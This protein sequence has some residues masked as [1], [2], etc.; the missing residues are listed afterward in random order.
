MLFLAV[1]LHCFI[2][3]IK[4]SKD[5]K[6]YELIRF[7]NLNS[8]AEC[9]ANNILEFDALNQHFKLDLT[10]QDH[11]HSVTDLQQHPD[12]SCAHL[13]ELCH[14]K[15]TVI[16]PHH[17]VV[18]WVSIS[19]C[20]VQDIRVFITLHNDTLIIRPTQS[21]LHDTYFI[22][23]HSANLKRT[24]QSINTR[25][26]LPNTGAKQ[27]CVDDHAY[28]DTICVYADVNGTHATLYQIDEE[29]GCVYGQP[30]YSYEEDGTVYYLHYN[31]YD[32]WV[33]GVHNVV[34]L[35]LC[36]ESNVL[37]CTEGKWEIELQNGDVQPYAKMKVE[38]CGSNGEGVDKGGLAS[39][40]VLA[41]VLFVI[42]GVL[43]VIG[44]TCI[45]IKKNNK[46]FKG[47]RVMDEEELDAIEVQS[48][49][50]IQHDTIN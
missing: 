50:G 1:I 28:G 44:L 17:S 23:K 9:N 43:I 41:D 38:A 29:R 21:L 20:S 22:Y 25:R 18:Q 32:Q 37:D 35:Y 2:I 15:G 19:I 3:I 46:T 7:T 16:E 5:I 12:L 27:S 39:G 26:R 34:H 10:V 4:T 47:T 48:D 40:V 42:S 33:I 14:Y 45:W 36:S 24:K 49:Q 30:V 11:G 8:L 13:H 6:E 31:E